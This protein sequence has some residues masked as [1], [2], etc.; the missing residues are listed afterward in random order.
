M[1]T[2]SFVIDIVLAGYLIWDAVEFRPGYRKLKQAIAEGNPH[3]RT[4]LYYRALTFEWT[5]ALLALCALGFSWSKLNP[6]LLA[7]DRL[8]LIQT[9]LQNPGLTRVTNAGMLLG[10]AV[11]LLGFVV[12]RLMA[13]RRGIT[14]ASGAATSRW[15][16]LLPDFSA[17]IP[18]TPRERFLFAAV[19]TSAGICEEIVFRGWLLATLHSQ[20]GL[21]GAMLIFA[22]AVIFGV[23]HA[24]QGVI[25]VVATAWAGALFCVVY[26]VTGSLLVPIVLHVLMDARFA[27]LPALRTQKP[28]TAY[29]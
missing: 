13:N 7:L 25:G 19:A 12:A 6:K 26:V 3:A 2:L 22:A 9:F 8:P 17:L 5:S 11:G 1:H 29:A 18:V 23:M 10:I 27:F 24:Y 20:M 28:Q 15:Q 21:G 4:R 16:K 14:T